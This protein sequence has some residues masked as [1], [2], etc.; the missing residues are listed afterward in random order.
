MCLPSAFLSMTFGLCGLYMR[1]DR[2]GFDMKPGF[3]GALKVGN[4]SKALII[5]EDGL[6]GHRIADVAAD[7]AG[8]A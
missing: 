8:R 2:F 3:H 1:R 6:H 4:V 7:V 5:N